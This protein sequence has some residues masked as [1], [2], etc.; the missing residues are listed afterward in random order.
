MTTKYSFNF[1]FTP[2]LSGFQNMEIDRL[3]GEIDPPQM[4]DI[5]FFTWQKPSISFGYN[6]N[7][8]KRLEIERC[9]RDG[10]DIVARPTGGREILHG[11]DLCCSVAWP[12]ENRGSVVGAMEIFDRI[13]EILRLGLEY[14]GIK[15]VHQKISS[16]VKSNDGPCFA[17]I[18]RGEISVDGKKIIA[19][20]QRVFEKVI[21]QQSSIL[22]QNTEIDIVKYL[23]MGS[24]STMRTSLKD[25]TTF[26][27]AHLAETFSTVQIVDVFRE[28][29]EVKIGRGVSKQLF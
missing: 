19:S 15:A 3:F 14:L 28:A 18:I 6:Q 24:K 8:F 29:F 5:R 16:G 25:S 20:A 27:D 9:L 23:K 26:L 7:P 2:D 22:L 10:I 13:N 17:Q 4:L 1:R 21:L 12:V 11:F